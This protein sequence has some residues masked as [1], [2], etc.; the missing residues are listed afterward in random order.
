MSDSPQSSEVTKHIRT[1]GVIG[2][3][4][5]TSTMVFLGLFLVIAIIGLFFV[6]GSSMSVGSYVVPISGT[7]FMAK[8]A[9]L[10]AL[11]VLGGGALM[12]VWLTRRIFVQFTQ[13][14]IF[15]HF[16]AQMTL[17]FAVMSLI[18]FGLRLPEKVVDP[19][20]LLLGLFL[21]AVRWGIRQAIALKEEQSL[22]I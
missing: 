21:L 14:E 2:R 1:V 16:V 22:T 11:I 7:N 5:C 8:G 13:G 12:V 4:I 3:A 19:A 6:E 18:A 17:V 9:I 10:M 20:L 15:T